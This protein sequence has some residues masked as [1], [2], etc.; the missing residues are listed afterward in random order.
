MFTQYSIN[1]SYKLRKAQPV[2]STALSNDRD[3]LHRDKLYMVKRPLMIQI[4][5]G[6]SL[7]STA[8]PKYANRLYNL[9]AYLGNADG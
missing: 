2:R 3:R 9:F 5:Q 1:W 7:H 8:F 4:A 6:Q